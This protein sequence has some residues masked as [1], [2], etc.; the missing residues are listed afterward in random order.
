MNVLVMGGS[1]F[2]GRA[3][4]RVL[5]ES[6]HVVSVCNRGRTE[7][8]HP[9]GV[10]SLVADRTDH[11]AMRSVLG[12]TEWDAVVDMTAYHP[13]DTQLM[14]DIFNGS[15]GHYIFVSSCVTYAAVGPQNPGPITED[16]PDD[17]G[18]NQYEYGLHKLLA[19]D[20]LREAHAATGFPVTTVPL[21]MVFGPHNAL[22]GRE[23]RMFSR[24]LLGRPI[25]MPGD[26]SATTVVGHVDDQ[27]R[28]FEALLGVE[29]SFGKR[30]NL[31]GDDP[32]TT[33]RYIDTFA[34]VVGVEPQ[35]VSIPTGLM[36]RLWDNEIQLTPPGGTR[37]T[38]DIRPTKDAAGTVMAHRHKA[39]LADL[40]QRIQSSI[41]RWDAEVVFS[42]DA[43][44]AVTGWQ[45]QFNFDTAVE[46]TY[47]WWAGTDLHTTVD[48]D[49]TY[50]DEILALVD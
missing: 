41:H 19:E 14:T 43:I 10:I 37:P 42:V 40:S 39:P 16:S 7:I 31:T 50:E 33:R 9:E 45:P 15:V 11:E 25:L 24:L 18:P 6:G 5:A 48:Q 44:K 34:R 26:G 47:Q 29:A 49:Y 46:H 12:G 13:E 30:L 20:Q 27:A 2:N 32:H 17:R 35:V 22:P 36:D 38:M 28:A 23:Q 21:G 1:A 3:L 4:V 8:D